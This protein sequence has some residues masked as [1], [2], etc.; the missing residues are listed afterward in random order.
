MSCYGITN[1]WDWIH[2]REVQHPF[3]PHEKKS[4]AWYH[5]QEMWN[6]GKKWNLISLFLFFLLFPIFLDYY[7]TY[8]CISG[9]HPYIL[10]ISVPDISCHGS[11]HDASICAAPLSAQNMPQYLPPSLPI[12][13][14]CAMICGGKCAESLDGLAKKSEACIL[15]I[16]T[17]SRRHLVGLKWCRC[18][19][20]VNT[21]NDALLEAILWPEAWCWAEDTTRGLCSHEVYWPF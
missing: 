14:V 3:W 21:L 12:S 19:I 10:L 5:I 15:N 1:I 20:I 8:S 13:P 18:W 6:P 4:V 17:I 2:S 9:N 16:D 11:S 7:Q